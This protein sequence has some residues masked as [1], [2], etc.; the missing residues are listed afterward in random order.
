MCTQVR[1]NQT[2]WNWGH[3]PLLNRFGDL[4]SSPSQE[5]CVCVCAWRSGTALRNRSLLP[6]GDPE[7][8]FCFL[9][10]CGKHCHSLST[11]IS[12]VPSF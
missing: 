8:T 11:V 3:R 5:L 2:S 12:P 4:N 1:M 9:G 7:L 10:L 6:L